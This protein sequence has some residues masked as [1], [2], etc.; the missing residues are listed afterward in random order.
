MTTVP[1]DLDVVVLAGGVGG[2]KLVRGLATVLDPAHLTIVVNTADDFEHLGVWVSPDLDTVMHRLAGVHHAANGW[3]RA[4]DTFHV[5]DAL[6][7]LGGPDWFRLGDKDLATTLF[8]THR[9]RRGDALTDITHDL[10]AAFGLDHVI[11]PMTDDVVATRV[12]TDHGDLSFQE[13]FVERRCEPVVERLEYRGAAKATARPQVVEAIERADVVVVA[14]SNPF[15][16]IDPILAIPAIGEAVRARGPERPTIAISPIVGGRALKGPAAKLL[17]ELDL[18]VS[19]VG[20]AMHLADT[21]SLL[22]VDRGD[23]EGFVDPGAGSFPGPVPTVGRDT[24]MD[25]AD[26]EA[27][28]ASDLIALVT[29]GSVG[30]TS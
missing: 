17:A 30:R 13:Y 24:V 7:E 22:V 15:L 18:P 10:C 19:S 8:R 25:S 9:R 20:V 16:S 28:L 26:D 21:I 23:V 4:G 5:M 27:R 3:G 2:S 29:S 14:P 1:D 6:A 12:H 11:F